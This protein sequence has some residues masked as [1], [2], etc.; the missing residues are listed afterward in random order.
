M[1]LLHLHTG[2]IG[3]R[4]HSDSDVHSEVQEFSMSPHQD[5]ETCTDSY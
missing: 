3:T 2:Y 1:M 4:S 5:T